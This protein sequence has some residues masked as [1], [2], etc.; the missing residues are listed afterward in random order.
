MVS[1]VSLVYLNRANPSHTPA[2][3]R[4]RGGGARR[5]RRGGVFVRLGSLHAAGSQMPA[6]DKEVKNIPPVP[7][8]SRTVRSQHRKDALL[9]IFRY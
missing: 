3:G 1:L 6:V 8:R 2:G 9:R 5:Q 4:G 7:K